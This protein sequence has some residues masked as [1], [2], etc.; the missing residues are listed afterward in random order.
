M[1]RPFFLINLW[2]VVHTVGSAQATINWDE[3]NV[4]HI[5]AENEKD[6]FRAFGYAQMHSHGDLILRLYG[7]SRGR[8]AEYWGESY[9]ESDI[10]LQTLG[11]PDRSFEMLQQQP[12]NFKDNLEAFA[13]GVNQYVSEN[14]EIIADS[15]QK[16]L[17]VMPEDLLAHYLYGMYALFIGGS[18]LGKI[19]S[20]AP[21][22]NA[23]AIGPNK[24]I[25]D[26]TI[27]LANPHLP[28]RDE[29]LFYEAHLNLPDLNLYG[30]TLVGLP[31]LAIAF[32]EHLGWTHTV[33]TIDLADTY[34]L[35]LTED[36]KGYHWEGGSK[37]FTRNIRSIQYETPA[38]GRK[39]KSFDVLSSVHGP[40]IAFGEKEAL[41]I[42]LAGIQKNLGLYQWWQMGKATNLADFEMAIEEME[43]P[44][45]NILY[46]DGD[47]NIFYHFN[48]PVPVRN[49]GDFAFWDRMLPGDS[50]EYLWQETHNY[51]DLPKILNPA[52]GW[53]QNANDPPW[54]S[55]IP[56]ELF[57][58]D[59]PP[60]LA[61]IEMGFR[62]QRSAKML[63]ES[64][65]FLTLDRVRQ[66]KMSSVSELANRLIPA[67]NE[68]LEATSMGRAQQAM[69]YLNNWNRDFEPNSEGAF[70]F[71]NW[72]DKYQ[73]KCKES[74]SP[75]FAQEWSIEDPINTPSGLGNP[76]LAAKA[77]D[78]S[79]MDMVFKYRKLTLSYGEKYFLRLGDKKLPA[80]GGPGKYGIFKTQNFVEE[81]E[82]FNSFHGDSYISIA[83]F[84]EKVKA[85]VLLTYGNST[86]ENTLP[87]ID[88]L[89]LYLE[90]KMRDVY[91]Y[92]SE[93][94]SHIVNSMAIGD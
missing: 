81:G 91:F 63:L 37:P 15:L 58:K 93:L 13:E 27:L 90:G 62:P 59:Y 10:L 83:E 77:L 19:Q 88:Q 71:I 41:A 31:V 70:L 22:S 66:L 18:E 50:E 47:G 34:Q 72:L 68:V 25:G 32:N 89:E 24:T 55:S 52:A 44:F 85:L 30:A 94:E 73:Q 92:K 20:W 42:R 2:L 21:G 49:Q 16:L 12:Q 5:Y 76:N 87:K 38:D 35:T 78:E 4:P 8:A 11:F 46:A 28:W 3:W 6:L 29:F 56:I 48:G 80:S 51:E 23:Y 1:I 82:S 39:S 67:L 17:P 69:D 14:P 7:V 74:G 36:K 53:I 61:P 9:I 57:P 65:N 33:N 60:Y 43:M 86:Q 40:I 79:A 64:G 84:G 75:I 54:T 26:E 45:F